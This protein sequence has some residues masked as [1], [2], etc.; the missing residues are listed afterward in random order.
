ML[1]DYHIVVQP[2]GMPPDSG[3]GTGAYAL[4]ESVLG[5]R[6]LTRKFKDYW[7]PDVGIVESVETLVINDGT[8]R[9]S[10]LLTGKVHLINRI[11]P[12]VAAFLKG[13]ASAAI[14]PTPG[15]GH[16]SL[17]MRSDATP[18]DNADLRMALKLAIDRED[19]VK[20]NMHDYGSVANDMP[21][22]ETYPL[23]TVLEQRKYD[24]AE[25]G[26]LY[27]N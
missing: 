19:L 12:K 24:P 23:A 15:R 8:V 9:V 7:R 16:F 21:I 1:T 26:R 3:I 20:R 14:V 10:A 18:F 13:S 25:V 11:E 17:A 6:Y 2:E 22:N 27:K 5:T 4:S